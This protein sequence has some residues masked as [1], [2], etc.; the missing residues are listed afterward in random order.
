MTDRIDVIK[1]LLDLRNRSVAE[2]F[3]VSEDAQH[4]IELSFWAWDQVRRSMN[5]GYDIMSPMDQ[6]FWGMFHLKLV[7]EP[8]PDMATHDC[9]PD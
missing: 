4:Q 2:D 7:S 9:G 6:R 8:L 5:T 3:N 1:E